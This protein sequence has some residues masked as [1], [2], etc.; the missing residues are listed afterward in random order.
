MD[1]VYSTGLGGAMNL[2]EME[3]KKERDYEKG[4]LEDFMFTPPY[5]TYEDDE[6]DM[7]YK[8]DEEFSRGM[9]SDEEDYHEN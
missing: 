1:I 5:S 7:E 8:M 6:L 4:L 9:E 3:L 2:H